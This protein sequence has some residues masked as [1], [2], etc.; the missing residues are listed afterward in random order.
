MTRATPFS[1]LL[2][3]VWGV[4]PLDDDLIIAVAMFISV[5]Y[6]FAG[7][8][9]SET[10]FA[11]SHTIFKLM[12]FTGYFIF[13]Y[14]LSFA[15]A[16]KGL[17]NV[18]FS[19]VVIMLY[20]AVP[21][22]LAVLGCFWV[23]LTRLG[24][25]DRLWQWQW[26][27]IIIPLLLVAGMSLELLPL[28]G[29]AAILFNLVFLAHCV[30][31]IV[32]GSR[33]VDAKLVSIACVLFALLTITRYVDLFDSLLLRSLVFLLLGAGVVVVGNFYSRT[34]RRIEEAGV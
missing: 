5:S 28:G 12:G 6:I 31:F 22:A 20:F 1:L 18:N 7:L 3:L 13:L 23:L 2:L 15:K 9:V 8:L 29:S 26:A 34:K 32:Q 27:L 16:S 33:D 11:E 14:V 24:R 4:V 19:R 10:A 30:L 21:L 17:D 25:L